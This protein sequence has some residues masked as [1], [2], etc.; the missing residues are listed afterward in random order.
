MSKAITPNPRPN[1]SVQRRISNVAAPP[2]VAEVVTSKR[3]SP[4]ILPSAVPSPPGRPEADPISDETDKINVDLRSKSG[5]GAIPRP[6]KTKYRTT[7]SH[8]HEIT[9]LDTASNKRRR[10][11]RART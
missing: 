4:S 1:H 6:V 11:N 7:H 2:S 9:P 3:V 10:G 5:L 8:D